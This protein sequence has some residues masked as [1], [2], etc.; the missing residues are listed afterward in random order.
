MG[1]VSDSDYMIRSGILQEQKAYVP[2][3]DKHSKEIRWVNIL[4][5]GYRIVS[6]AWRT[7]EQFV[8]QPAFAKSDRKFNT[9]KT[10]KSC[11]VASDR[12]GN[13]RAVRIAKM[14]GFLKEGLR[15]NQTLDRLSDACLAWSFQANFM[16]K[17]VL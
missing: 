2:L 8:L 13:E 4:D 5:K 3:H 9:V 11:A 1:A 15:H 10:I 6:A 16:Y 17:P 7:G 12:G 14:S